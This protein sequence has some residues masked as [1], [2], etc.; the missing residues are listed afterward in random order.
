M[1]RTHCDGKGV[2]FTA[3]EEALFTAF[4]TP[5][6]DDD[7]EWE[8]DDAEPSDSGLAMATVRH[9]RASKIMLSLNLSTAALHGLEIICCHIVQALRPHV[10]IC[11]SLCGFYSF[12]LIK[13]GRNIK[14]SQKRG[15]K[16][17]LRSRQP[18]LIIFS[19]V[20]YQRRQPA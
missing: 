14:G 7:V 3:A 15:Q 12:Y 1:E 6:E 2:R 13:P 8:D 18:T 10:T 4:G 17:A 11:L 19:S 9:T 20:Q 5:L 16:K